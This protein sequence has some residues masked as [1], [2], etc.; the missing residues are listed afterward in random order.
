[1]TF[2][3]EEA[4]IIVKDFTKTYLE[5]SKCKGVVVGLS[6]G[7]DSAVTALLCQ[8]ALGNNKLKCLFFPEE[9]TPKDDIKHVELLKKKI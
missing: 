1:M 4:A 5:S 6:G 7:I 9:T 2:N 3:P 8:K